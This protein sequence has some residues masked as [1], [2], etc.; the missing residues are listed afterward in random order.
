MLSTLNLFTLE[1][2][3]TC[4]FT[5]AINYMSNQDNSTELHI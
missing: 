3:L 4:H 2:R 1:G 5:V